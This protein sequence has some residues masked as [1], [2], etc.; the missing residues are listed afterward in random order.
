M[1]FSV[2]GEL[3]SR[4]FGLP[5]TASKKDNLLSSSRVC[6]SWAIFSYL[7]IS[8]LVEFFTEKVLQSFGVY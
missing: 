4:C 7:I 3:F 6:F 1:T 2:A 5:S 8:G